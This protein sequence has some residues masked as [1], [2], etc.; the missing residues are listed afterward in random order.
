[1]TAETTSWRVCQLAIRLAA[2]DR[3][4]RRHRAGAAAAPVPSI[5][6]VERG[7]LRQRNNL[8]PRKE[9]GKTAFQGQDL[10]RVAADEA[11]TQHRSA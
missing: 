9:Q 5:G 3:V 1:M 10:R 7:A 6:P 11:A 4:R 2:T 8:R